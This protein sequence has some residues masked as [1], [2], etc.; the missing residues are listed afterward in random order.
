MGG[1]KSDN[2]WK[3]I[4]PYLSKKN[5]NSNSKIILSENNKL[6]TDQKEVCEIFNDFFVNVADSIGQGTSFDSE[7]H[8]SI[9][10]IKE[11]KKEEKSFNFSYID[12]NKVSKLI[13][14]LQIKKAT[15]VDKLSSKIIKLGK[16]A[17]QSPLADL[18]NLSIRTSTFPENLKRAQLAPL[19]KKNDPMEKS[20]FRPVSVLT[21]TSKL[22]EK[23]L[24]EQLSL[25]F[26]DIFDQYL[27]AFRKGHG[28]Q[29]TLL[30]LLEDW[31]GA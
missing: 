4:K 16:P 8:P 14:K 23:V 7:T 21:T 26:D 22:Y 1:P 15:G 5:V 17:L 2:F 10:K 11:N 9:C 3:T 28:C 27:C 12:E 20:N 13:D 18:I 30:R 29:T 6:V 31:R 19:H 25:Y 24:S